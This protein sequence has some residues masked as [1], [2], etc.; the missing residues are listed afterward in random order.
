MESESGLRYH[1][2]VPVWRR[3]AALGIDALP[4]WIIAA[5]AGGNLFA[6]LILFTLVWLG[7]RVVV[8]GN[9]NGQSLGRWAFDM[10]VVEWETGRT[11]LLLD[12]TR[13]EGITAIGA[14]L[15]TFAL[16]FL[17]PGTGWLLMF[18]VPLAADC[19]LAWADPVKRQAFHDRLVNTTVIPSYRG[20]SLDLKLKKWFAEVRLRMKQ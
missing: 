13:R 19:A 1:P 2:K 11:P 7:L 18:P 15:T 17:G 6:W 16:S 4:A 8:A 5:L 14:G 12:L 20:F 3:G 10:R 9:F